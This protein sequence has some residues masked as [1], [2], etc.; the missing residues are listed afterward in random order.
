M[1]RKK[2]GPNRT[3]HGRFEPVF[4][5]VRFKHLKKIISVRLLILAQNRTEP[6]ML[7][8]RVMGWLIRSTELNQ[9]K[10]KLISLW[11]QHGPNKELVGFWIH[12]M[13]HIEAVFVFR[14]VVFGKSLSK[15]SCVCLSLGKLINRKHFPIKEKFGL[16]SR[17]VFSFYFW[18]ENTFQKL[19][20]I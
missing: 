9:I 7:T 18:T 6:K 4:G 16:I 17:K 2:T 12:P 3:E 8:P 14:K 5:S 11:H 19:W 10:S 1:E 20:K 13:N 15:L